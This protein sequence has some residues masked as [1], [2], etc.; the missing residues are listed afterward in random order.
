MILIFTIKE[1]ERAAFLRALDKMSERYDPAERMLREPFH[2]PGYHTTLTGGEVHSTR[3]AFQYAVLLLDSGRGEDLRRA[4]DVLQRA[5]ALQDQEMAAPTFGIWS[6]FLEEPLAQM[7]PPDWN[8][9]DFCGKELTFVVRD[10]MPRLP[11][12]LQEQV[13]LGLRCACL[14]I[15]RRNVQPDYTNISIMG[16]Y[17]TLSAGELCGWPDMLTYGKSRMK[18]LHEANMKAGGFAEYNS[19]TYSALAMTDLTRLSTDIRDE[20]CRAMAA[21][22]LDM[23]WRGIARHYHPETGAWAG[24]NARGYAWLTDAKIWS[25]LKRGTGVPLV[26]PQDETYDPEWARVPHRCPEKYLPLFTQREA[27]DASEVFQPARGA[28]PAQVAQ[29]YLAP[30]YALSSFARMDTWNQRRNL[31]GHFGTPL[32][33]GYIALRVLHD[34]YDFSSGMLACAQYHGGAAFHAGL[35]TDGGDTHCN[36]DM[37]KDETISA[38]DMRV[39]FQLGGPAVAGLEAAWQNGGVDLQLPGAALRLRIAKA[40][41]DGH[42]AAFEVVREGDALCLDVVLFHADEPQPVR[43]SALKDTLVSGAI[44][45]EAE[46]PAPQASVEDA[47]ACVQSASEGVALYVCAPSRPVPRAQWKADVRVGG[48]DVAQFYAAKG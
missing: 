37:I 22:L 39:R 44:S 35:V 43:L 27:R 16:T 17:V 25:L 32:K 10:H 18:R 31:A 47:F 21:E 12:P 13:R 48:E 15:F 11:K 38:R 23:C 7:A 28:H 20:E 42:P 41:W 36:L 4:C 40:V 1:S 8:W 24:P 33:Q 6:W 19:P 26:R 29:C 45:L 46:A 5:L 9:A 34:G 14:S 2:T 30:T 3:A